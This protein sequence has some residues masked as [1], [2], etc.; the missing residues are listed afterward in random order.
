MNN[1]PKMDNPLVTP[2]RIVRVVGSIAL[3]R[4][5]SLLFKPPD[6]FT[7]AEAIL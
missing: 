7:S 4:F 5:S 1:D 6:S 2:T 3:N